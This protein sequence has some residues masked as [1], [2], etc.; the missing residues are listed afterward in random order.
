[1]ILESPL[2]RNQ[3]A[4]VI[5]TTAELMAEFEA[6]D[7]EGGRSK[8]EEA[9]YQAFADGQFPQFN[10]QWVPISVDTPEGPLVYFV[11]PDY[12]CVG[13]DEDFLRVRINP[14]IAESILYLLDGI[15]PTRKM[16][17][18]IYNASQKVAAEPWGPPYDS[19]M[20]S[21]DRWPVQDAKILET[22]NSRGYALGKPTAGHLKD[23]CLGKGLETYK[24]QTVGIWGWFNADGSVIQ[25]VSVNSQT[26]AYEDAQ[27]RAH[28]WSY[29]DYSHGCRGV[30][31]LCQFQD[32]WQLVTNLF[33]SATY[34]KYIADNM[35]TVISYTEAKDLA[36]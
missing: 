21:L 32:K 13:S 8:R 35:F 24:G 2:F 27:W 26:G 28:E 5:K 31:K 23:V 22:F 14:R 16:V 19:S 6:A 7:K 30:H 34:Y 3:P 17:Q 20:M 36:A 4:S 33:K 12:L 25:G 9:I 1:M 15:L 18:Q 11:M 10:A 29:D